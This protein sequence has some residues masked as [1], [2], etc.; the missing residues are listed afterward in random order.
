MTILSQHQI[1]NQTTHPCCD[2]NKFIFLLD[3]S[4][5]HNLGG[6]PPGGQLFF[7]S[8]MNSKLTGEG[9]E[10]DVVQKKPLQF[11]AINSDF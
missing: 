7:F 5:S 11:S 1:L 9:D 2:D 6:T 8:S 4:H 10:E 3:I